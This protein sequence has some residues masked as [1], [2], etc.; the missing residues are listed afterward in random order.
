MLIDARV[1]E[2][3]LCDAPRHSMYPFDTAALGP[4]GFT[5][6]GSG[7]GSSAGRDID[8]LTISDSDQSVVDD[9][10]RIRV[11]PLVP[12]SI[13]IGFLYDVTSGRLNEVRAATE[14]GQ[15]TA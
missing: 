1:M 5:N 13:P 7:P 12:G 10:A 6:V 15:P 4:E 11:H 8:W 14:A 9:V 2:W 3:L